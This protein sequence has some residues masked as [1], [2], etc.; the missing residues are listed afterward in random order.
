MVGARA[1]AFGGGF[2]S[3]PH[4]APQG[5]HAD[6]EYYSKKMRAGDYF[7][8]IGARAAGQG[9]WRRQ[10][11]GASRHTSQATQ[12]SH[13]ANKIKRLPARP[14]NSPDL[15]PCDYWLLPETRRRMEGKEA[16]D[17]A[18]LRALLQQTMQSISLATAEQACLSPQS[19]IE[20]CVKCEG[21]P[22]E[23]KRKSKKEA[24]AHIA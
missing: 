14:A 9:A 22:F 3:T 5:A 7:A 12:N 16:A 13:R 15:N 17:C 2:L 10:E 11:D 4:F 6:S 20:D 19:R 1:S 8:Q 21:R 18:G 23:C 24:P